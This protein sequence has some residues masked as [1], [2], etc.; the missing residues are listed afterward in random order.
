MDIAAD[1]AGEQMAVV[2][3]PLSE[4]TPSQTEHLLRLT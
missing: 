1:S 4:H 2:Y 3:A